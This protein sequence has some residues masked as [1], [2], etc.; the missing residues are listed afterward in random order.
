MTGVQTCALPIFEYAAR[1]SDLE[2]SV[3]DIEFKVQ[4]QAVELQMD[5]WSTI[6]FWRLTLTISRVADYIEDAADELL[7]YESAL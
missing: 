6:I 7:S 5:T 3:D 2:R 1:I 4:Q